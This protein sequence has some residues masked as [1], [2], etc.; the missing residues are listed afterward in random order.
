[1][2]P[3]SRN[4]LFV[5]GTPRSGTTAMQALLAGDD[6][7]ALGMERYGSYLGADFNEG[8]FTKERFF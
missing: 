7:I 5:C 2:S 8:L 6:R 4:L 1:M 3:S